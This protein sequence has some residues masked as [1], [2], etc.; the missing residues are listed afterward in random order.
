M[1]ATGRAVKPQRV[2]QGQAGPIRSLPF[3]PW[4]HFAADE[5]EAVTRVLQ[6]GKVNYWTGEEGR[7]FEE[8]FAARQAAGTP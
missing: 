7:K 8:E 3:A 1:S 6:S 2:D 5:T 4:P